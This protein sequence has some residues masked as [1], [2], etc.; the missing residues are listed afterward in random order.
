MFM[1]TGQWLKNH[2][3]RPRERSFGRLQQM[4][5]L[6]ITFIIITTTIHPETRSGNSF[7]WRR[8][9]MLWTE[10]LNS[11]SRRVRFE[12]TGTSESNTPTSPAASHRD[13]LSNG[14]EDPAP[15]MAQTYI[16]SG[17]RNGGVKNSNGGTSFT[18][19]PHQHHH[20]HHGN[21]SDQ[22][23]DTRM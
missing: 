22:E 11:F 23:A 3:F 21:S 16:E 20:H 9:E 15:A 4:E 17:D 1:D 12:K 2:L 10:L 5:H 18:S 8:F 7:C 13:D 14:P 6:L 19:P